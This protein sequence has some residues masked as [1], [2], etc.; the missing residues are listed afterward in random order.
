MSVRLFINSALV[1]ILLG[2]AAGAG[3][4]EVRIAGDR[5]SLHADRIPLRS[6]LGDMSRL[7]VKIRIAPDLNPRITA[8]FDDREIGRGMDSI[9]KPLN[10]ILIWESIDGHPGPITRLAEIQVFEPGRKEAMKPLGS[11]GNLNIVRDP[12]D[13]SLFVRD[14]LLLRVRQGMSLSEFRRFLEEIKGSVIGG[15]AAAGVLRIRL[16]ENSD[17]P[18]LL[19]RISEHPGI[20]RAEP[21]YAYPLPVSYRSASSEI[22]GPEVSAGPASAGTAPIAIIDT[23]IDPGSGLDRFVLASLDAL[24]PDDPVSDSVGHGTQMAFIASG[25][26][27]PLGVAGDSQSPNPIIPIRAFDD[28]GYTSDFH[29]M[30]SIEYAMQ[31]GAR[32]V[33]LSWG[34]ETR[35]AFLEELF[36]HARDREIILV[37]SAGNE[38]TGKP[39]YP[40]AYESVI[41]VGALSPDG[42]SWE[43][44]NFG[45]F[46]TLYA[47]GFAVLPVGY[48]GDPGAYAGTSIS[49]AFVSSRIANYLSRNPGATAGE[50]MKALR[51]K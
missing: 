11:W 48:Q 33:S 5:L 50:V 13:G 28:N 21:N 1:A 43:K 6:I 47:P 49:A 8:S 34:S 23:G 44:S 32:V 27:R 37:A 12:R 45:D 42:R 17:L 7:G 38:P 2:C 3:A 51:N 15:S 31:K 25:A 4:F 18:A 20:E 40:A 19:M 29:L 35:S 16:A 30:R 46:V 36:D 9:L 22:P 10:Y 39:V 14:E 24:N 26:V 41:G